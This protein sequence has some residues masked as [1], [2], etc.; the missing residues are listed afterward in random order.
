MKVRNIVIIK[1]ANSQQNIDSVFNTIELIEQLQG[2]NVKFYL[3][4]DCPVLLNYF[5][6]NNLKYVHLKLSMAVSSKIR[7]LYNLN[8]LKKYFNIDSIFCYSLPEKIFCTKWAVK[9]KIKILWIENNYLKLNF[10]RTK[11]YIK[12]SEH[13]LVISACEDIKNQITELGVKKSRI[14]TIYNSIDPQKYDLEENN[15][16]VNKGIFTLGT[17]SDLEEDKGLVTLFS[18]TQNVWNIIPN[19]YLVIIGQGSL[20]H[21]LRWIAKTAGISSRTRIITQQEDSAKWIKSFNL[22]IAPNKNP[23]P[24][25]KHI[26]EAQ[27]Y[28]KPVI[29]SDIG[30]N[31]EYV[32]DNKTGLIFPPSNFEVLSSKIINLYNNSDLNYKLSKNA[33]DTLME[34][35]TVAKMAEK[36]IEI[37]D[38]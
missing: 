27:L 8:R 25:N 5:H 31:S 12:Y 29:T 30:N 10:L 26:L 33:Y 14:I 1:S 6:K 35:F 34:K 9:N 17:I 37:L 32:V 18:A 28:K 22:F 16:F 20:Q 4:S 21:K 3:I 15:T 38:E 23:E 24:F 13:A 7:L 2:Y 19:L 36:Y 11:Q